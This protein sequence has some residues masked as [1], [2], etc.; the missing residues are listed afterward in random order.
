MKKPLFI[1]LTLT[2]VLL[3]ALL[4]Y[5][6]SLARTDLSLNTT[7]ITF[8]K[9]EILD[10]EEVRIYARVFNL[11]DADVSGFVLFQ[12]NGRE[13]ANPQPISVKVNTYDDVFINWLAEAGTHNIQAKIIGTNLTD[14]NP[15]N[16]EAVLDG[17]FVDLDTDK[18]GT[19]NRQDIDDDNDGLSDEKEVVLGTD[20]LN[21]DTDGDRARDNIDPFP[22][23]PTEWQDSDKDGLGDNTDIDDDNDGLNDEEEIFIFGTNSLNPDSDNDGLS[24]KEEIDFGTDALQADSDGDGAID[25]EDRFPLDPTRVQASILEMVRKFSEERGIPFPYL[26]GGVGFIFLLILFIFRRR[27]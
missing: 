5:S 10:G 26:I 7:D 14:E 6:D 1:S 24:D 27:K 2:A 22:L 3:L 13:M 20:S 15:D 17:Y 21:P 16:D 18:D 8:S 19:G 11:G 23:D 9:E 12:K 25:S 4:F